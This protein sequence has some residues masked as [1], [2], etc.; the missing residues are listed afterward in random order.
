LDL[1]PFPLYVIGFH[2]SHVV[3]VVDFYWIGPCIFSMQISS[4]N[5]ILNFFWPGIW[6]PPIPARPLCLILLFAY[7]LWGWRCCILWWNFIISS[8][9]SNQLASENFYSAKYIKLNIHTTFV[10]LQGDRI[11]FKGKSIEDSMVVVAW[12]A[13][14]V[15]VVEVVDMTTVSWNTKTLNNFAVSSHRAFKTY[16]SQHLLFLHLKIIDRWALPRLLSLWSL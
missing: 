14:E 13:V 3:F 10:F 11:L 5:Q 16:L 1:F 2:R 15:V 12:I 6:K 4:Q 8:F 9:I 7:W